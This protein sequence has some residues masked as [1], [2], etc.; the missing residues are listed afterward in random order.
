[1][2]DPALADLAREWLWQPRH[3][4]ELAAFEARLKENKE[5]EAQKERERKRKGGR[6]GAQQ[7]EALAEWVVA[8]FEVGLRGCGAGQRRARQLRGSCPR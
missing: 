5:A 4:A 3:E 2:R 7:I 1:V 6:R 8:M